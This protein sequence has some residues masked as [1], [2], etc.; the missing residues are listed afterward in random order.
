MVYVT[1]LKNTA[2]FPDL[3]VFFPR[4]STTSR[5]RYPDVYENNGFMRVVFIVTDTPAARDPL[6]RLPY[7]AI[8]PYY[9]TVQKCSRN[10]TEM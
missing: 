2:L 1:V 9:G 4:V 5:F 7:T 10:T 3:R 8:L 6:K